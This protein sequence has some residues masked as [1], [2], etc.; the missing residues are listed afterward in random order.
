MD[1]TGGGS[2]DDA[3]TCPRGHWRPAE[4]EK[5]RRL[6]EQYG[7]QNWNSIA[8]KLQGRSGK[9]CRLR[10]FNQ[11]D[12]RINRRPF[13]EEEEERLFAA[14][15]IHGNKWALISRLFPGRTDN[16]VK[17]HWH[18]IMARKQREQSKICGKRNYQEAISFGPKISKNQENYSLKSQF[19]SGRLFGFQGPIQ[20]RIYTLSPSS[21]SPS[22]NFTR[23]ISSATKNSSSV[24]L[25]G[26]EERDCFNSSSNSLD[27]PFSR[28][29]LNSSFECSKLGDGNAT[30]GLIKRDLVRF[31]GNSHPFE[32]MRESMR[33]NMDEQNGDH[34]AVKKKNI[35][36]IDFLGVGI[37]S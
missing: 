37:S 6:V 29:Y 2:S 20:D 32:V 21:P 34:E 23:P 4:D 33:E 12:P 11:L 16:A 28:Y 13:S 25:F 26:K 10:W 24:D 17:N 18:V 15:R 19:E 3:R 36:F 35:P 22:W 1:E 5:L 14:H 27:R 30:H 7:P 9:S 8:E 31:G